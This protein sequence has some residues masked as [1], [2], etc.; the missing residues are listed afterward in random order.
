M[1]IFYSTKYEEIELA[2]KL[3][4]GREIIKG[5]ITTFPFTTISRNH[6]C[7]KMK[8]RPLPEEERADEA[9][10]TDIDPDGRTYRR[11]RKLPTKRSNGTIRSKEL[12]AAMNEKRKRGRIQKARTALKEVQLNTKN[13]V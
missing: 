2:K 12:R 4:E 9:A 11:A 3:E 7:L 8:K 1:G 13:R 10:Y 5:T 6:F